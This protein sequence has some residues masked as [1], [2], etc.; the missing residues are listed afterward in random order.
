MPLQRAF[1]RPSIFPPGVSP[2]VTSPA[3][4]TAARAS[5]LRL[6]DPA[7]DHPSARALIDEGRVRDDAALAAAVM[8]AESAVATAEQG[9]DRATLGR[10]LNALARARWRQGRLDDAERVF[11][12]ALERGADGTDP[13]LHVEVMTSLAALAKI[14][15]DFRE[16]LR[17]YEDALAQGRRHSLLEH[18]LGTLND[19]GIAYMALGRLDAAED[20]F[21]EGLTIANALGGLSIRITL[22][23]SHA[24]LQIEKGD[25]V[26]AKRRC[27]NAM[28]LLAHRGDARASAEVAK[29]QGIVAR[30]TGDLAQ[31]E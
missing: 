23:V 29:I 26:E 24:S 9:G 15:G 13:R 21:T 16:A 27:D 11:H 2:T 17:C 31:A 10:A 8:S 3:D 12:E 4:G 30:E 14:R 20:A 5:H 22:E 18:V 19:V 25:L 6:V 1:H 7:M 28:K